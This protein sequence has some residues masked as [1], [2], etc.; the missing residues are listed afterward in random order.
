MSRDPIE[1]AATSRP[2]SLKAPFPY[3]GGKRR[4]ASLIW[5]RFGDVPNY[6]EPFAGSL[7]VLLGRPHEPGIETVNDVDCFIA[8]F[9]RALQAEPDQVADWADWPV[10]EADLYARHLRLVRWGRDNRERIQAD[11]DFYDAQ[12]AGWWVWGIS[13][14]IG[15]GWCAAAHATPEVEEPTPGRVRGVH[16]QRPHLGDAGRGVHRQL[17]PL[18]AYRDQL[19]S[20]LGDLAARLRRVRVC[21]GD[22]TR[23]LTP[24]PTTRCGL[25][26]IFLDPP[27]LQSERK[28]K[29]YSVETDVSTAVRHWAVEHGADPKLRIC[30]AGYDGEHVMPDDWS[31]VAWRGHGGYGLP[32]HGR[33]RANAQR[34]RLWFSPHCLHTRPSPGAKQ[35]HLLEETDL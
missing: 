33:G 9:W 16:R 19:R 1:P 8:N 31:C 17:P 6:V 3:F 12:A 7:A 29:V 27:Y 14:W 5:E 32:R 23:V 4:V 18:S 22:W 2:S 10:I 28:A 34:E 24:T 26:A 13:Q 35:I 15:N 30:L 21:C 20:Y 25:T 11:P